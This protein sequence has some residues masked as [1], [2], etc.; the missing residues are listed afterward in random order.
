MI[1][2]EDVITLA[3]PPGTTVAAGAA[4]L[5]REVTWAARIRSSPPAMATTV[6]DDRPIADAPTPAAAA[7]A[8]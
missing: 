5:G 8:L 6:L 3:L 1:T 7:P 4:G 2:V